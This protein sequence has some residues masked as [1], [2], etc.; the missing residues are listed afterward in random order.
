MDNALISIALDL[1]TTSIK[2]A[3]MDRQGN[4]Q[5]IVT[6]SA[7]AMD[8]HNGHYESNALD[9][10]G[11]AEQ[12]LKECIAQ[13]GNNPPLGLCTQ[14]SSFLIWDKI[15]GNPVTPLISWQD[16]RGASCC[17]RLHTS[18]DTIH[19]LTGLRLAAYYFAPKLSFLL[20]GNPAWREKLVQ[21]EWLAGTLDT[22]LIW[23]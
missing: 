8:N 4:L 6:R 2:A 14:R 9:Y 12:V 18:T 15:C 20:Q 23:R 17:D 13:T 22:F 1:G 21:G 5:H 11:I 7:P 16:D 3:V 10:A 19:N